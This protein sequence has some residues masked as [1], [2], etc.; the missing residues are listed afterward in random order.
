MGSQNARLMKEFRMLQKELP[1]G[2]ICTPRHERLDSYE[3]SIEGPPNTPYENGR[4]LIDV[5][6][7]SRYPIEPPS[8][9]FKSRIYHPNIDD[10][11]NICL[12]ILKSGK[13]GNWNP[14]WT[15]GK[16]LVSMT[17]L[18]SN[19]NPHD[20]LMPE[21][22]DQW[23]NDHAGFE[24]TAREWTSKYATGFSDDPA[25]YMVTS[26]ELAPQTPERP[27]Q[28]TVSNGSPSQDAGAK[29]ASPSPVA[30]AAAIKRVAS[31][32]STY[33]G[34]PARRKLG[35][36]R[37]SASPSPDP[38]SS[39][40]PPLP[41]KLPA[42]GIR[43]LGL[44][45]NRN[46]QKQ[47]KQMPSAP[48]G[49]PAD[50]SSQAESIEVTSDDSGNVL[51]KPRQLDV[52][53]S[54]KT[55]KSKGD[56]D[57]Q[58]NKRQK[59]S[60]S[61]L[62]QILASNHKNPKPKTQH[63]SSQDKNRALQSSQESVVSKSPTHKEPRIAKGTAPKAGTLDSKYTSES[64][65]SEQSEEV[66]FIHEPVCSSST[67]EIDSSMDYE[68][69]LS[70][71]KNA[72][73]SGAAAAAGV[74]EYSEGLSTVDELQLSPLVS[75]DDRN[76][77]NDHDIPVVDDDDDGAVNQDCSSHDAKDSGSDMLPTGLSKDTVIDKV[78]PEVALPSARRK[79]KGK[80]PD[81]SGPVAKRNCGDAGEGCD[82][83]Q[84][85]LYESHFGPLELGLPPI[86]VSA[87]RKLMR[88]RARPKGA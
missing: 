40:P 75:N 48:A 72:G 53:L 69:L 29:P 57:S 17:V 5:S 41:G 68:C 23:L 51:P 42:A 67:G 63:L 65:A 8:L 78:I 18:L 38:A 44:S 58:H 30:A 81:L 76:D 60:P 7:S 35:L 73:S 6:L 14:S 25:E 82:G 19:P 86:R 50:E 52:P 59:K 36:S 28:A 54:P 2:I 71:A 33:S 83:E 61:S 4:F 87:Q 26:Q 24:R 49:P 27:A 9:K 37:K 31:T 77:T 10:H 70:P 80:A 79:D 21:I 46:A 66:L 34:A 22:A 74:Y 12:D 55:R 84:N 11:G 88:R 56:S 64:A 3:A 85:V 32:D 16:V 20:P 45:R 62:S 13:K 43:R 47:Q 15:L 1:Q 39:L